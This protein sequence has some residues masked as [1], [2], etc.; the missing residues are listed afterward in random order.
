MALIQVETLIWVA[1]FSIFG[2]YTAVFTYSQ[3]RYPRLFLKGYL[4]CFLTNTY[5]PIKATASVFSYHFTGH[6]WLPRRSPSG[7]GT[8]SNDAGLTFLQN[9]TGSTTLDAGASDAGNTNPEPE[10]ESQCLCPEGYNPTPSDD[11]CKK[12]ITVEA[13]NEGTTYEVCQ[14]QQLQLR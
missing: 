4:L 1:E 14:A 7:S 11:A 10:P 9:E 8:T 3:G 6:F 2:V 12:T 5:V 13:T